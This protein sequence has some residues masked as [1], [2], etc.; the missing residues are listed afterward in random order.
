MFS[1][2]QARDF[3]ALRGLF[4]SESVHTSGD[5]AEQTGPEAVVGEVAGFVEAFP[6]LRIDIR[7]Q[8]VPDPSRSIIEYTFTG[9]HSGPLDDVAPTGRTVAVPACSVLEGD[10]GT[11][12]RESDYYD[13]MAMLAQLGVAPS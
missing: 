4:T 1:A 5:G 13:T 2:I 7:H 9:T 8:H 10:D 3:D 12:R 11:I 6:D